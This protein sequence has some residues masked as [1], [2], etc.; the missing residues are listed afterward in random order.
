MI[1]NSIPPDEDADGYRIGCSIVEAVSWA[2]SCQYSTPYQRI[3]EF[4][5]HHKDYIDE[6][7]DV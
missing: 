3:M 6:E 5:S 7:G 4:M 1:P 2:L